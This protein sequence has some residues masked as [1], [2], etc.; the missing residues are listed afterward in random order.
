MP[1]MAE[2]VADHCFIRGWL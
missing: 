2:S 1:K